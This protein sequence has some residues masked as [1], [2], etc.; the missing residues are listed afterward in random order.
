[1]FNSPNLRRDLLTFALLAIGLTAILAFLPG[2]VQGSGKSKVQRADSLVLQWR[3][4]DS[5]NVA[6]TGFRAKSL[7]NVKMGST[8]VQQV[9]ADESGNVDV[10]VPKDLVLAGKEG[11][12]IMVTGRSTSGANRTL[13]SAVPPR[14]AATGP[15]DMLPWS[16]SGAAV[17]GVA[18]A[19]WRR[20]GQAYKGR[21]I[22]TPMALAA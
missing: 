9:R 19:L 17:L 14:A 2:T 18:V 21:H 20:R 11:S 1:M 3:N 12:S 16:L 6:G 5:L 22:G 15:V 10:D 8:Q 4:N 7:V 13:I